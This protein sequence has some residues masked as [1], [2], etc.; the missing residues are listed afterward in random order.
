MAV[1]EVIESIEVCSTMNLDKREPIHD[2]I[3]KPFLE[4]FRHSQSAQ[5]PRINLSEL[6]YRCIPTILGKCPRSSW[7]LR[8]SL[9]EAV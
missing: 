7:E 9:D 1:K 5:R 4:G 3:L 2:L 6:R 8:N